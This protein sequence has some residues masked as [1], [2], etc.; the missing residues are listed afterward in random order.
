[1]AEFLSIWMRL[2]CLNTFCVTE[3]D[4]RLPRALLIRLLKLGENA[5]NAWL[6]DGHM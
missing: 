1:M 4:A 3:L 2:P 5:Y 6:H